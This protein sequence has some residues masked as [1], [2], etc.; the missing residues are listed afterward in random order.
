[1]VTPVVIITPEETDPM[2]APERPSPIE[3]VFCAKESEK[4]SCGVGNN[5]WFGAK[6]SDDSLDTTLGYTVVKSS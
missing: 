6:N 3:A 4:C 5:I 2:V 1:M